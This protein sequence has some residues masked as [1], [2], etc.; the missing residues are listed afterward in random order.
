MSRTHIEMIERDTER[1]RECCKGIRWECCEASCLT[2]YDRPAPSRSSYSADSCLFTLRPSVLSRDLIFMKERIKFH[3][4]STIKVVLNNC[5]RCISVLIEMLSFFPIK[6]C[7]L[8]SCGN[9][10]GKTSAG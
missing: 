9:V 8:Y 7:R 6:E 5:L 10:D 4:S 1:E 2:T 3:E